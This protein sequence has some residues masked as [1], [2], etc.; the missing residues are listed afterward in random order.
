MATVDKLGIAEDKRDMV[1]DLIR[2]SLPTDNELPLTYQ[3]IPKPEISSFLICKICNQEISSSKY[4]DSEDDKKK[5]KRFKALKKCQ[6]EIST[7]LVNLKLGSGVNN[8]FSTNPVGCKRVNSRKCFHS[9]K[10]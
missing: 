6:D 3:I 9:H 10:C 8:P 4:T 7:F 5:F 1:L 2:Y